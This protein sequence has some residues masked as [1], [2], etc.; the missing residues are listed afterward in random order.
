[1]DNIH[2][3]NLK[4]QRLRKKLHKLI[5][6]K[7]DNLNPEIIKI[8]QMLDILLNEYYKIQKEKK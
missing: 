6:E 8:S 3:I 1:M 7:N 5:D 2:E 4:I